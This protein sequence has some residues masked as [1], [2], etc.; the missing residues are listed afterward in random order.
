MTS[1]LPSDLGPLT[2]LEVEWGQERAKHPNARR[3]Q[4]V[5]SIGEDG[6]PRGE[7]LAERRHPPAGE[8]SEEAPP[9]TAEPLTAEDRLELFLEVLHLEPEL[10]EEHAIQAQL[11]AARDGW[12]AV[13]REKGD[14]DEERAWLVALR[15]ESLD[16]LAAELAQRRAESD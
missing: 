12:L 16:R 11:A 8:L 7:S 14:E 5:W 9:T 15:D 13:T 4:K 3:P 1:D 2:R 10:D 6:K